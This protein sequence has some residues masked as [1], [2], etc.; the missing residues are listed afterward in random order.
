MSLLAKPGNNHIKNKC[1]FTIDHILNFAGEQKKFES[2]DVFLEGNQGEGK[3]DWLHCTRYKP[4]KLMSK[5]FFFLFRRQKFFFLIGY[6][7]PFNY[8]F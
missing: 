1:N 7:G 2:I 5:Y 8:L 3:F 4:P 6:Y